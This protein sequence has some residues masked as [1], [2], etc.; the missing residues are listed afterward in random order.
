MILV[1]LSTLLA[2]LVFGLGVLGYFFKK[3]S[4]LLRAE[5][6]IA[7]EFQDLMESEVMIIRTDTDGN[8]IHASH[9]FASFTGYSMAELVGRSFRQILHPEALPESYEELWSSLA[10]TFGWKDEFSS[11][12]SNGTPFWAEVNVSPMHNHEGVLSGFHAVVH[13]IS[14]SKLVEQLAVTDELTTLNNRRSFNQ[15]FSR[16]IHRSKRAG[17]S[18]TFAILDV[19]HFKLYND[20]YGHQKGDEVLHQVGV[21]LR[22]TLRRPTD[23][24]FRLGGEEFGVLLID[25]T[26]EKAAAFLE[27]IRESIYSLGIEHLKNLNFNRISVSVGAIHATNVNPEQESEYFRQADLKLYEAKGSGRNRLIFENFAESPPPQEKSGIIPL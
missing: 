25:M 14:S 18:I 27:H 17:H 20:T 21:T 13:D 9:A 22:E 16:E 11:Q 23:F 10:A 26:S 2:S 19:D 3:Q 12:K 1:I 15:I 24:A 8:V 7:K 4:T 6:R 5:R